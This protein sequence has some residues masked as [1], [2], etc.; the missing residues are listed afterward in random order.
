MRIWPRLKALLSRKQIE[1][2]M[3]AELRV[4][5]ELQEAANRA[6]G[7][8]PD[9]ARYAARRQFGHLD[10]IKE[11]ARDERGWVWLGQWGKD[12]RFSQRSLRRS[13]SF[14]LTV[15]VTLALCIGANT[16]ILSVLYGLILKPLPFHDPGQLVE[17]YNS[18][19]KAGQRKRPTSV[20][21]YLD[22]KQNA[23]LFA[24]F[25]L[26]RVWTFNIGEDTGDPT[27]GIGA[28]VTADYF[29]ILGVP[30][31]LGRFFTM[32]ESVPGNDQVVVLTQTFWESYYHA[33]PG[34]V[35]KVI[36][37]GG[38]PLTVVGVAPR[39]VEALNRDATIFKPFE[40]VPAQ[41]APQARLAYNP[42]MYA[43]LKPGVAPAAGLAQLDTLEKRFYRDVAPPALRDFLDR[44]GYQ[45]ALGRVRAEQTESVKTSLLLLQGGALFVLLLGCVNVANLMLARTNARQ[46]ELA[47]RQ[48]LGA[49]RGDLARQLLTE[50]LLLATAGAAVGLGLAWASLR[51]IN[52]YTTAII[53]E[54]EPVALDGTV[55][56]VTLLVALAV[57]AIIGLLPVVRLWRTDSLR[58]IQGGARCASA[59]GGMRAASGLLVTAQTALALMLLVG[60]SLLLHSFA[61]VLQV[62]LGFDARRIVQARVAYNASYPDAANR[63]SAQERI[64]DAMR[65]IPGVEAVSISSH[66]PVNGQFPVGTFPIRG[67][68]L[69][70]N[71]TYPTASV[72]AV[73]PDFFETMGIRIIDGRAFTAA[74]DLQSRRVC[75][76][77]RN[78]AEKYFPGRSPVGE[79]FGMAD[80]K[81]PPDSWPVIVGVAEAAKFNGPE[82]RSGVP[83]VF[84]AMTQGLWGGF[85]L[86]LRTARP[87]AEVVRLMRQR[88]HAVDPTLP[89]YSEGTLQMSIDGVLANRRGVLMLLGAF[90]L[91]ALVLSAVGIY[92]MLAYD[93]SQRT[94]EIGIRGAIGASRGQIVA[95]ILRQGMWKAGIGL[96]AGLGGAFYLTRFLRSMLFD[97]TTVDPFSYVAVSLLLLLV[98]LLAC[99]LPARRAA[100]VDPVVA[101]RAE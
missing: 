72:L 80:P 40:W 21:Q 59:G 33:D 2:D 29:Q 7:M 56:W 45:V 48:A 97:I 71:D 66:I 10:G 64:I 42:L 93:V 99:W 67:S 54:V 60:A 55:L 16:A 31:L 94:R 62:D 81:Q 24:G 85:S 11:T 22:Y 57:A 6:A 5:L 38:Y 96:V 69:G 84:T 95:L 63:K 68:A 83:F 65:I 17:T 78:F 28:R 15:I 44:N 98:A 8:A 73:R 51:V 79:G 49:G 87:F 20:A 90:A 30:P 41:G 35:G 19:P 50:G 61:R 27:R 46:A 101:L 47:I 9:E 18:V 3:A 75:M 14:S 43:R 37:L 82:D 4:H 86:E 91:I 77:D 23:D 26:W 32:E 52:G 12:L 53:R 58:S 1:A 70:Q 89:L 76:V 25:A 34:I 100:K 88:L 36:R 13:T 74:D 92:G 39:S